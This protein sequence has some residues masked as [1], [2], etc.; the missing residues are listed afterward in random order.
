MHILSDD[1]SRCAP[2]DGWDPGAFM[3]TK[4]LPYAVHWGASDKA[5]YNDALAKGCEDVS[6]WA[7]DDMPDMLVTCVAA[8]AFAGGAIPLT[9]TLSSDGNGLLYNKVADDF[10]DER[11]LGGPGQLPPL[12]R[13]PMCQGVLHA[14]KLKISYD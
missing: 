13:N 14:A 12:T 7:K 11:G 8:G 3:L 1:H 2:L 5:H 9:L 4:P 6:A 10:E